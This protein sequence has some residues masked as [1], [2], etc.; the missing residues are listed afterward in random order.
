[1]FSKFLQSLIH[2]ITATGQINIIQVTNEEAE[3]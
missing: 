3:K 1:M 2:Q